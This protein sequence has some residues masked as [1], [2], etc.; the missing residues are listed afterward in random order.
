LA[1]CAS[2]GEEYNKTS[3]LRVPWEDNRSWYSFVDITRL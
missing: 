1:T 3:F 2:A